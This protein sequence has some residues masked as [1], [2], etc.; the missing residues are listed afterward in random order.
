LAVGLA[1]L[2]LN[3]IFIRATD[4]EL[5][6]LVLDVVNGRRSKAEVAVFLRVHERC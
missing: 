6:E 5:V 2:A 3:E 1:F 4:D